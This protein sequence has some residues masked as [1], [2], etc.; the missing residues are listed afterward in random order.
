MG[1]EDSSFHISKWL[2][3][4]TG[5]CFLVTLVHLGMSLS[6]LKFSSAKT[7]VTAVYTQGVIISLVIDLDKLCGSSQC[8]KVTSF[9]IKKIYQNISESDTIIMKTLNTPIYKHVKFFI[10][11]GTLFITNYLDIPHNQLK[12]TLVSR[13][14]D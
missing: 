13:H 5:H 2:V 11:C 4:S 12:L 9:L 10:N 3:D 14:E 6:V 7:C 1:Q 8:D